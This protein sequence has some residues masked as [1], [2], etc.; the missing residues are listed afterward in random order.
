MSA[1]NT[2]QTARPKPTTE[3]E[4]RFDPA[5]ALPRISDKLRDEGFTQGEGPTPSSY[6]WSPIFGLVVN[7]P[8]YPDCNAFW[9]EH[10]AVASEIQTKCGNKLF[11]R[12]ER[13]EMDMQHRLVQTAY[14]AGWVAR[15][16]QLTSVEGE[17]RHLSETV[18][19]VI[20]LATMLVAVFDSISV[21]DAV[22]IKESCP[23]FANV[24]E[25]VRRKAVNVGAGLGRISQGTK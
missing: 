6:V 12:H 20:D 25:L 24:L 22:E 21:L 8:L 4:H 1:K 2:A 13:A 15:T 14:A 5:V 9:S 19:D 18:E 16:H 10:C 3:W 7:S 23:G 11:N 17:A